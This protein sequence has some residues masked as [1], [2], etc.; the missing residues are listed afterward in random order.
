MIVPEGAPVEIEA[1]ILNKDIGF[2][3][4]GQPAVPYTR[5]GTLDG[6]ITEV[7]DD[8]IEGE[9]LG[10]P[11]P[12]IAVPQPMLRVAECCRVACLFSDPR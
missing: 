11:S 4:E 3:H 10:L 12:R 7:S 9:K 8:A 5:Y 1:R 2:V 6:E